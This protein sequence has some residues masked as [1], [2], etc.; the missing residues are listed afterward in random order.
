MKLM[1]K[2]RKLKKLNKKIKTHANIAYLKALQWVIGT[3]NVAALAAMP[4]QRV[5]DY[6]K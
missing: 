6:G 4:Q 1:I 3:D 5:S 2:K